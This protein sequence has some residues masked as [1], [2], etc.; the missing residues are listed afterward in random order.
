MLHSESRRHFTD[1]KREEMNPVSSEETLI[2]DARSGMRTEEIL[3]SKLGNA[4]S[5]T[6]I[7]RDPGRGRIKPR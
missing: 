1:S 6:P 7:R 2:S 5:R 4:L 3:E